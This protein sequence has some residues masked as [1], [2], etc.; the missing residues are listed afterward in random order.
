MVRRCYDWRA[1][2]HIAKAM[3]LKARPADPGRVR[4]VLRHIES[5]ARAVLLRAGGEQAISAEMEAVY[6]EQ[7]GL[8]ERP[9]V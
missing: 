8:V 9:S 5:Q 3:R 2:R 1:L 6:R 7:R 4:Y